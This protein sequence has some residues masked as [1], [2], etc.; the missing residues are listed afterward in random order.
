MWEARRTSFGQAAQVYDEHRPDWPPDTARWLT[1]TEPGG[2]LAGVGR[3]RL[4][5]LG[6]GTGKLTRTLLTLG[7]R[8]M[9]VEPSEGMLARLREALP[10]VGVAAGT[11]EAIP[12]PDGTL[13]AV[14][15]AQA[16]HW[17]RHEA[18]AAECARVLLPGGVLGVAWHLRD[19]RVPWV[20]ELDA[21]VQMAGGSTTEQG[22]DRDDSGFAL[23]EPFGPVR[24]AVFGY[25]KELTPAQLV[26]LAS[27]WSYVAVRPDR[28]ETLRAVGELAQRVAGRN[29]RLSLPF[30][31]HCFRALRG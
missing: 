26:E 2:P 20:A 14:T 13:D 10:D 3:L 7:H 31:T 6:A 29:G 24:A 25:R 21:L 12:L 17:F 28:D 19:G 22:Q 16:W 23:P 5:D 1:G 4:L 18:A 11:A 9:A 8:V 15:V 30:V 27:S